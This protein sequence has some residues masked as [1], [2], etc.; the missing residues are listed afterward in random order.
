MLD[1]NIQVIPNWL[2][3][4]L[5][6][7][8]FLVLYFGL[9][10]LLY[11][12]VSNFLQERE[13]NI[14]RNIEEAS[15]L[16]EEALQLKSQYETKIQEAKDESQSIIESGRRRGQEIEEDIITEARNEAKKIIDRAKREIE[17]E[18]EKVLMEV[19]KETGEMAVLIASKIIN[20]QLDLASQEDLIA[21]FIDEVGT[22]KWQN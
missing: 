13:E 2:S 22:S 14:E 9:K 15:A 3:M 21:K 1:F 16:K 18:K 7:G 20:E 4:A 6:L 10:K 11:K 12:P 8:A 5:T 19:Q 17:I